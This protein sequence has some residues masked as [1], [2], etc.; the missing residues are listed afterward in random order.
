MLLFASGR[1]PGAWINFGHRDNGFSLTEPSAAAT[2]AAGRRRRTAGNQSRSHRPG[3]C[4][5]RTGRTRISSGCRSTAAGA[6]KRRTSFTTSPPATRGW[7]GRESRATPARPKAAPGRSPTCRRSSDCS[8]GWIYRRY[9]RCGRCR[10]GESLRSSR[11]R[12]RCNLQ[13]P[14]YAM[15]PD[16]VRQHR[17]SVQPKKAVAKT[18][19]RP[20]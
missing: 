9:G 10:G 7:G 16:R 3:R 12:E 8:T 18:D 15:K 19:L 13:S 14:L 2:L 6:S 11:V 1:R 17:L 5:P 4:F 20:C